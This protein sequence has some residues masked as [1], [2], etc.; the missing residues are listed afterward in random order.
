[1]RSFDFE[2]LELLHC[3]RPNDIIKAK[4]ITEQLGGKESSTALSTMDDELG[5][6]FSRSESTGVL[7][8]PRSW[9]Q[10]QCPISGRKERRKN[11][12]PPGLSGN[13]GEEPMQD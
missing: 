11:A 1:M 8:I 10:S 5:V 2:G 4:V 7:M 12:P 13:S 3:F 9:H 6:V